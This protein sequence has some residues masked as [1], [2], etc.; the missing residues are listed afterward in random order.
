[1]CTV[2]GPRLDRDA[3]R[4]SGQHGIADREESR[5]LSYPNQRQPWADPQ[6]GPMGLFWNKPNS[7]QKV[8]LR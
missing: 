8:S 6:F 2:D 5:T 4:S 7:A 1:M 3:G